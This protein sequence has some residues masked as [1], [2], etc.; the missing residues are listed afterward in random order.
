[1]DLNIYTIEE[2]RPYSVST[3]KFVG[4][5]AGEDIS[6]SEE[7]IVPS[8][9]ININVFDIAAIF[10][11][12]LIWDNWIDSWDNCLVSWDDLRDNVSREYI[13]FIWDLVIVIEANGETVETQYDFNNFNRAQALID[14]RNSISQSFVADGG[15]L[16]SASFYLS[17]KG[18]V[19]GAVQAEI[20]ATTG[21]SGINAVPIGEPLAISDPVPVTEI[22]SPYDGTPSSCQEVIFN[23]AESNF[24]MIQGTTYCIVVHYLIHG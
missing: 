16:K 21:V 13:S 4:P 15:K 17:K 19:T 20:F 18:T 6:I 5:E 1:M 10:S 24:E 14:P 2:L 22:V 7:I 9:D 11:G 3:L 23:F 8:I 12:E